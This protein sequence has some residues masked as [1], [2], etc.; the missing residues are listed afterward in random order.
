[1]YVVKMDYSENRIIL[2]VKQ[3]AQNIP[4]QLWVSNSGRE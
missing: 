1:M 4:I 3:E 2:Y